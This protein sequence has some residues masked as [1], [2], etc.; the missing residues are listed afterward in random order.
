MT[1]ADTNKA[2]S[3]PDNLVAPE[4]DRLTWESAAKNELDHINTSNIIWVPAAKHPQIAPTEFLEWIKTHGNATTYNKHPV[5]RQRS[6]LSVTYTSSEEEDDDEEDEEDDEDDTKGNDDDDS[7]DYLATQLN[8]NNSIDTTDAPNRNTLDQKSTTSPVLLANHQER[9][10]LLRRRALSSRGK[11][12]NISRTVSSLS[13]KHAGQTPDI[14][15]DINGNRSKTS[16]I[17]PIAADNTQLYDQPVS[18]NEWVDLGSMADIDSSPPFLH[19][20]HSAKTHLVERRSPTHELSSS[21]SPQQQQEEISPEPITTRKRKGLQRSVSDRFSWTTQSDKQRPTWIRGLFDKYRNGGYDNSKSDLAVTE[22]GTR[23]P[24]TLS[25]SS[26]SSIPI[27]SRISSFSPPSKPIRRTSSHNLITYLSRKLS[28]SS[29]KSTDTNNKNPRRRYSKFLQHRGSS[30]KIQPETKDINQ[31]QRLPIPL[32]RGVYRLSHIKLSNPRRPLREQ[33]IISNFMFWYL[34]IINM[35]PHQ[36]QQQQLQEQQQEDQQQDQ[37]AYQYISTNNLHSHNDTN[38]L[39]PQPQHTPLK[40][41]TAETTR[42][43]N[44]IRPSSPLS[45]KSKKEKYKP[46]RNIYFSKPSLTS[47]PLE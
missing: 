21:S 37:Q 4:I 15:N 28:F 26:T 24:S 5:R 44:L 34:S 8:S 33:V 1:G 39:P 43:L 25:S 38:S 11:S 6:A 46:I 47:T 20:M 29:S 22:K 14:N 19:R 3:G 30:S 2:L 32:E 40:R 13:A 12:N 10:S 36:I 31:G 42:D 23:R 9:K 45:S 17:I 27:S 18:M 7:D 41:P 35:H 16:D